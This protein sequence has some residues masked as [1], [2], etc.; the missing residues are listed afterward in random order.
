MN[1]VY[2]L[3]P[4]TRSANLQRRVVIQGFDLPLRGVTIAGGSALPGILIAAIAWPLIGTYALFLVPLVVGGAFWLV[5]SRARSGLQL[6]QYQ[7]FMDMRRDVSGHFLLCGEFINPGGHVFGH[8]VASS[9]PGRPLDAASLFPDSG[10]DSRN[11]RMVTSDRKR[12]EIR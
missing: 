4:L 7:R 2:S 11:R 3:T 8:V 5:E 12:K 10:T 9:M 1:R 6:R